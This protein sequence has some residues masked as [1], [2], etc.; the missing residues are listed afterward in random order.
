MSNLFEEVL[1]D[2]KGVE[3]RLIGDPYEYY[4]QIKPPEEIGIGSKGTISQLVANGKGLEQYGDLLYFGTGSAMKKEGEPLG[5]KFFLPTGGK[6]K[7]IDSCNIYTVN[8]DTGE[9]VDTGEK[10][11]GCVLK[12]VER[13]IY[14][15]NVPKG[16]NFIPGLG[17]NLKGLVP[18]ML[19]NLKVFNPFAIM[20]A[21]MSGAVPDCSARKLQIRNNNNDEWDETHYISIEDQHN[22]ESFSNMKP[23]TPSLFLPNNSVVQFYYAILSILGIYILYCL[24]M[25]KIK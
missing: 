5:N 2:A 3:K 4:K 18:G 24:M 16:I 9:Q 1:V 22:M 10:T 17:D 7:D 19:G 21:F 25:R 6:C 11:E 13:Y 14:I 8:K 20:G 12:E 15:D 23:L